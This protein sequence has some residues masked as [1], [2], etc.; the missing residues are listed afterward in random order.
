MHCH[1]FYVMLALYFF[2]PVSIWN[3]ILSNNLYTVKLTELRVSVT[4]IKRPRE[5]TYIYQ[6]CTEEPI[7]AYKVWL[8]NLQAKAK[9]EKELGLLCCL[10]HHKK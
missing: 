2:K 3:C 7:D 4:P 1:V 10:T 9:E 8:A 6:S 5:S